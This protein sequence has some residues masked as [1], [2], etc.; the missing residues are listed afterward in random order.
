[1][2][3][4]KTAPTKPGEASTPAPAQDG[5]TTGGYF[6]RILRK[7]PRLLRGRSNQEILDHWLADHPGHTE[8]PKNIKAHLSTVKSTMR[9]KKRKKAAR[10]A[11][12][13]QPG[14]TGHTATQV[15][16]VARKA[17]ADDKLEGLEL[18]ID[19]CLSL[20]KQLDREGLHD[21]IQLLR[22]ARNAVVWKLGQ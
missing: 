9:S 7:N 10:R 12:E 8:V 1:M 20:A 21:V 11:E 18:Q 6:R 13:G 5:E 2:A 22:R 15:A 3:K 19:E 17:T 16:P 14:A 4:K